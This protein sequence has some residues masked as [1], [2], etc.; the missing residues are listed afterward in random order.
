M[1][2]D[3]QS[4]D[5]AGMYDAGVGN[6]SPR[7]RACIYIWHAALLVLLIAAIGALVYLSLR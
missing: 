3:S 2:A 6:S 1:M 5:P 7:D 4:D